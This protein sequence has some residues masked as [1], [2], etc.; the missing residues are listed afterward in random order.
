MSQNAFRA[1]RNCSYVCAR[2]LAVAV[3]VGLVPAVASAQGASSALARE[4]DR[5]AAALESRAVAWRRDFHQHP[6]LSNREVRTSKIVADHLRSLGLEVKTGVAKNGVV[7]LLRGGKPGPVVAL[8]ADMDALPVAEEVDLPFKSTVRTQYL[9]QEV[10][11]M[12]ACG[13]DAH[14]AILMSVAEVL[15]GMKAQLPGTVKFIFQP[16]EEGAPPGEEGGAALMIKEGVLENP[17][18]DAIF[19][20]HVFPYDAGSINY[21]PG[22][23]MASSDRF[24]IVVRGRQTHGGL[25]WN[26]VDPVVVSSQIVLGLQTIT[27]RQ[28]DLI[29]SPAVVT[30]GRFQAGVRYNIVPD[31]AVLEGTIRTFSQSMRTSIYDRIKRTAESIAAS[32]GA[33]AVVRIF[34]YT[35]VTLNN[36]ALTERMIPTLRRVAGPDKIGIARQT[37]TAEDFA[38]FEEKVPGMFFFLG[39]TPK[40]T[41]PATAAPNHSPRFFLDESA[42]VPGIRAMANLAVDY[43]QGGK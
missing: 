43:L 17:K 8:R 6:E 9:G 22:A 36:P 38:L 31:S 7:G 11:V 33:T 2:R 40:G 27:S 37:T 24:E 5:R 41:D 10:G 3:V 35:G 21:R 4:I 29:E 13:H 30:V 39:I 12:H 23:I 25:P 32:A 15:A 16:S 14:T 18:V 26:G 28:I 42:I 1:S 19:G 34:P 20:L